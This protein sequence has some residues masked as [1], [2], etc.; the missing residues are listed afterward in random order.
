MPSFFPTIPEDFF[1]K[2]LGIVVIVGRF[3]LSLTTDRVHFVRRRRG[4]SLMPQRY[5]RSWSR[6]LPSKSLHTSFSAVITNT[7]SAATA[8]GFTPTPCSQ[9][10]VRPKK[11][12]IST[13]SIHEHWTP[14]TDSTPPFVQLKQS[15]TGVNPILQGWLRRSTTAPTSWSILFRV[16]WRVLLG[17]R[18]SPALIV[19][20]LVLDEG[21]REKL[22]KWIIT[23][24][25]TSPTPNMMDT[26]SMRLLQRFSSSLVSVEYPSTTEAPSNLRPFRRKVELLFDVLKNLESANSALAGGNI[27]PVIRKKDKAVTNKRRIDPLP[28]DSMGI[29]VPTTDAEVRDVCVAVLSQLQRILEVCGFIADCL[30]AELNSPS[31]I[32]SFSGGGS[33]R[34]FSNPCAPQQHC[35]RREYL[36]QLRKMRLWGQTTPG[37]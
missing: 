3:S 4:D 35:H 37:T 19:L 11:L 8:L 36:P 12:L 25:P 24:F 23:G 10:V 30:C 21:A 7:R 22:L 16:R 31:I 34:T 17:P 18:A 29:T 33:C 1:M 15:A 28:F 32:F 6:V 2:K 13:Y 14:Q 27:S 20:L 9:I 26:M 5:V